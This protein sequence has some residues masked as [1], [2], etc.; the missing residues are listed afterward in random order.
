MISKKV[1]SWNFPPLDVEQKR[2]QEAAI[3]LFE[4]LPS[5]KSVKRAILDEK[6]YV[7]SVAGKTS[8]W[9]R[10]G[11]EISFDFKE[12]KLGE[13]EVFEDLLFD[14]EHM[15]ITLKRAGIITSGNHNNTLEQQLLK[16]LNNNNLRSSEVSFGAAHRLDK[17]TH[18][19]VIFYK[20]KNAA[21]RLGHMFENREISK[22]Y[23]ALVH[24]DFKGE[25]I[26]I[27]TPISGKESHTIFE[28]I[29]TSTLPYI[30]QVSLLKAIPITG[31]KHQIRIHCKALG[32]QIVGDK[33]HTGDKIF[34]GHGMF[35]CCNKLEFKHPITE[36]HILVSTPLPR[37]FH[38]ILDETLLP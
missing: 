16:R 8:T 5:R 28:K 23:T 30:G 36:E 11:D 26:E 22:E 17:D 25:K 9:V 13:F 31:R 10:I 33:V 12:V 38:K 32:H 15:C 14:D 1:K 21:K 27:K 34:K 19:P 2:L 18:G 24:G 35:L 3:N 37:K 7:N 20:N 4:E 6:I 29:S